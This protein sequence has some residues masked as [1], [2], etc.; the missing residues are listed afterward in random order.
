[1]A[2]HGIRSLCPFALVQ[3]GR[4]LALRKNEGERMKDETSNHRN[5]HS[6]FIL[7]LSS[8]ILFASFLTSSFCISAEAGS[9]DDRFLDELERRSF[10]F[11]WEQ[12]DPH[13]GL[14]SDRAKADG[15]EKFGT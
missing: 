14:I 2:A 4:L 10:Q 8:L 1:M 3:L 6:I 15:G 9:R 7:H 11:F 13:T 5:A 12:T